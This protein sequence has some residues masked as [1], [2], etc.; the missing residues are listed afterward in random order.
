[1]TETNF[2]PT[3]VD[4][5]ALEDMT[6]HEKYF[7]AGK[8]AKEILDHIEPLVKPKVTAKELCLIADNMVFDSGAMPAFPLNVS[9]NHHAAHYT[10][11]IDD[12]LVIGDND[13]VKIDLGVQVDGFIADTAR[14]VI[15][16][17]E[18]EQLVSA[19]KEATMNALNSITPGINTQELGAM[20]EK[21]IKD[22]GYLPISDLSGH[23]LE[24]YVLHGDKTVPCIASARGSE[25]Q[26]GD[27]FAIE[28]FASTGSG[29]C[30]HD[31]S[32][33]LIFR[34]PEQRLRLRSPAARKVASITKNDYSGLPFAERW[35]LRHGLKPSQVKMGMRE[36]KNNTN[37]VQY[38]VLT[39]QQDSFV[40]QHEHTVIVTADGPLI[41]T[42]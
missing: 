7:L 6:E 42:I 18:F 24:K 20:T 40:S 3:K 35:L 8:I 15:F 10:A 32:K 23:L 14:T 33:V 26:E 38:P 13:V 2:I 28:T 4:Q 19:S 11:G 29:K 17:D 41:T 36:L 21:I 22:H 5:A 37:F 16:S 1:M 9:V 27:V 12:T 25:V 39:D 30:H 31:S 34:T